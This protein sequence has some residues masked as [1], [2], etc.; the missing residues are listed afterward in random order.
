[1]KKQWF[2]V[3]GAVLAGI[4]VCVSVWFSLREH[5][6]RQIQ[7]Q[8]HLTSPRQHNGRTTENRNGPQLG[9]NPDEIPM[10]TKER[11]QRVKSQMMSMYSEEQLANPETQRMFA[12]MDSPKYHDFVEKHLATGSPPNYGEWNDF[13]ES[14]GVSVKREY[15]EMFRHYFPTGEPEDYDKEMRLKIAEMF[16]AT[17][18]VDL[19]DPEA[20]ARQRREVI[21]QLI[22]NG[23]ADVAWYLG[24]FGDEWDGPILFDQEN[25]RRNAA[26]EWVKAVQQNAASIVASA[27]RAGGAALESQ[28]FASSWDMSAVGESPSAPHSGTEMPATLDTKETGRLTNTEFEAEI[29]SSLTPQKTD[30]P[31]ASSPD[32]PGE[33]QSNLE[34]SLK[35]Q[36]SSERFDRVM[37][38]LERYGPEEGLRRLRESDPEVA[39]QIERHRKR[40]ESK[41]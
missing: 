31:T 3:C 8:R 25:T 21:R 37:S 40:E 15:P 5:K 38:T 19:T 7:G 41:Q 30:I 36:F 32:K 11:M 22:K 9:K 16:F 10:D 12:V 28:G 26:T 39:K 14:Q 1:M 2:Y 13:W 23:G 17:K 33:I 20:A 29:E 4:A 35:E 34:A 24:R 27:E 18:P 6:G